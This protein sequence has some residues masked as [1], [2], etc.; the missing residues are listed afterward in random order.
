LDAISNFISGTLNPLYKRKASISIVQTG[1]DKDEVI[2]PFELGTVK[3]LV[4]HKLKTF[5]PKIGKSSTVSSYLRGLKSMHCNKKD[6]K[7]A[8]VVFSQDG[9]DIESALSEISRVSATHNDLTSHF[10]FVDSKMRNEP[11]AVKRYAEQIYT[12][13]MGKIDQL[14]YAYGDFLANLH[15]KEDASANRCDSSS[16]CGPMMVC[17]QTSINIKECVCPVCSE[18]YNLVCG[19]GGRTYT[20]RS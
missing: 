20:N 15:A 2:V 5:T 17:L 8:I 3:N 10:L 1:N 11:P 6:T 9:K 12:Y 18:N 4:Q 13:K 7:C 16:D 14:S 19:G